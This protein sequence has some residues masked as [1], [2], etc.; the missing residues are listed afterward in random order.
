MEDT[1]NHFGP[2]SDGKTD[3]ERRSDALAELQKGFDAIKSERPKTL[4]KKD[5]RDLVSL[6]QQN[7]DIL[8]PTD[9]KHG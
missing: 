7:S 1:A 6:I 4:P 8:S 2:M 5:E 3:E 9:K